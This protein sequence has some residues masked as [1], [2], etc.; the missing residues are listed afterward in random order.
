ME[1]DKIMFFADK[2]NRNAFSKI[3]DPEYIEKLQISD[4]TKDEYNCISSVLSLMISYSD[5]WDE[6]CQYNI[7]KNGQNL[8]QSIRELKLN[9]HETIQRLITISYQFLIELDISNFK[10]LTAEFRLSKIDIEKLSIKFTEFYKEIIINSKINIPIQI[11]KATLN[12]PTIKNFEANYIKLENANT[13]N[14]EWENKLLRHEAKVENLAS[15]LEKYENAYNFVG[16]Y[17]GY[18]DLYK[19]KKKEL[20]W[21]KIGLFALG[22]LILSPFCIEL[23]LFSKAIPENVLYFI[24]PTISI[25]GILIYFFRI[26]FHNFKAV[27]SQILQIEL[28]KTLLQFIQ[29]YTKY[30]K[31][32]KENDKDALAKFENIIFSGLVSDNEKLPSTYDGL[33]QVVNLIKNLKSA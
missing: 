12:K 28:R 18:N 7:E 24:F 23:I 3:I 20:C 27:K 22:I 31:E 29:S 2:I 19:N 10:D 8:L 21:L 32:I 17:K 13:Q 6:G 25:V 4:Q 16:L 15:K 26:V 14:E 5:F 9:D 30:S 11:L 33:D 1:K